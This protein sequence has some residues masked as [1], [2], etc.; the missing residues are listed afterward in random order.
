MKT[1]RNGDPTTNGGSILKPIGKVIA[2]IAILLCL[3][4]WCLMASMRDYHIR[5]DHIGAERSLTQLANVPPSRRERMPEAKKEYEELKQILFEVV[6]NTRIKSLFENTYIE[7]SPPYCIVG[8]SYNSVAAKASIA[9]V[10]QRY[11]TW[12]EK[13]GWYYE[14]NEALAED[15]KANGTSQFYWGPRLTE[16]HQ[17]RFEI[18]SFSVDPSSAA[19]RSNYA[20]HYHLRLTYIDS[21]NED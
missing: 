1:K 12:A 11:N 5:I 3:F 19:L 7:L 4:T 8:K 15:T 14:K 16:A 9:D 21:C 13:R 2:S 20:T 6:D 17:T 18:E 10:V